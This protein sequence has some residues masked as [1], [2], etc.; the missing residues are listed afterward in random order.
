MTTKDVLNVTLLDLY[1]LKYL[2]VIYIYIRV[3]LI[4][5]WYHEVYYGRFKTI[6]LI[7]Y[8]V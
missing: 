1:A 2:C 4:N 8:H 5:L 3:Y 6:S 7:P